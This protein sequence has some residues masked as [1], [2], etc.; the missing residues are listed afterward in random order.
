MIC[1]ADKY[2]SQQHGRELPRAPGTGPM[3]PVFPDRTAMPDD[4]HSAQEPLEFE[5]DSEETDP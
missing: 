1:R 5:Y 3:L 4:Y 2:L